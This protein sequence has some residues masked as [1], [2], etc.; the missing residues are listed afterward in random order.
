MNLKKRIV[1]S[2]ASAALMAVFSLLLSTL[3]NDEGIQVDHLIGSSIAGVIIGFWIIPRTL[4]NS[5]E[6]HNDRS[7]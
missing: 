5:Q 7:P 6:N 2:L 1:L 3:I 4:K